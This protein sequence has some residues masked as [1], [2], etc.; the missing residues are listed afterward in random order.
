LKASSGGQPKDLKLLADQQKTIE[1]KRSHNESLRRQ[2]MMADKRM[3]DRLAAFERSAE[4]RQTAK[5]EQMRNVLSEG[6]AQQL[7]DG[8]RTPNIHAI[9]KGIKK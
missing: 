9:K 7:A 3:V 2:E 8:S 1:D 5:R 4:R 6:L